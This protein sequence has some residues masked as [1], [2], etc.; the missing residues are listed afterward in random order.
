MKDRGETEVEFLI[1][2]I[3]VTVVIL[4]L[5]PMVKYKAFSGK[6]EDFDKPQTTNEYCFDGFKYLVGENTIS[7][8]LDSI[9]NGVPCVGE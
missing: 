7:P 3:L 6:Q 8:I 5:T 2:V 9:G 1:F 4:V